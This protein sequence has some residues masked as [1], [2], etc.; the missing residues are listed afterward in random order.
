MDP[1]TNA[2]DKYIVAIVTQH[3][4]SIFYDVNQIQTELNNHIFAW[5][6][7]H[8]YDLK[9]SGSVAKGTCIAGATDIDFFI[10]LNPSVSTCNTLEQVYTTLRNRFTGAGYTVREQNVSIGINHAGYKIDIVPGVK[11]HLL[12]LDHSIWKR[13]AQT[14]TKTNVDEHV[15]YVIGSGRIFDIKAIK[16]WRELRGLDFPS[17]YLEISVIE[18]LK[19]RSLFGNPS[20]N[21]ID[22]MNYLSDE[23]IDKVIADPSN[24]TNTVSDELTRDEKGKI[25]DAALATLGGNWGQAI[26]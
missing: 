14:W 16:I 11:H 20:G 23:F 3:T 4:P 13:K 9:L 12:G 8:S 19:G 22:V 21:F 18:A 24:Q 15:R 26:W 1:D 6:N 7:G 10:S 2:N 17:F 5:S 25:R